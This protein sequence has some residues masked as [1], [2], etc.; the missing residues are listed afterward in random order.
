MNNFFSMKGFPR[1]SPLAFL[2][3]AASLMAADEA[4][5]ADAPKFDQ[6]SLEFYE[7]EVRP[8]L[9]ERC[10]KCHSAAEGVS[11]GGLVM[12][13]RAGLI[14]GGD[15]GPS[16]VP[17]NLKKSLMIVAIHQDD[18]ELSMPPRKAGAKLPDNQ[19]KV[20][21]NWVMMGA[22][23]PTGSAAVKLTGLSQKARDHWA[24]KPVT[25]PEVPT[26]L[27]NPAWVQNEIDAFVLAKLDQAGLKPSP[28][29]D[30][31]ALIRRLTYDLHGLPPTNA[32]AESF[33]RE[34][35]AAAARDQFAQ[36]QG[37]ASHTAAVVM[38]RAVDRLLASPRYGERWARHWLDT[39]RYSDTKG[40]RRGGADADV[41]ASAWT[42]R[43]Y[44]I[45]AFNN[46]KPY[47]QFIIEQLAADRLPDLAKDDP[48]LAALGFIT[49]GKRFDNMDDTIDERIDT[50]SKAFMA[51]TVACARCHDHK[52][53]PIPSADY[54][55]MHGIF[56]STIEPLVEPAIRG[57]RSAPAAVR[58]DYE[59]QMKQLMDE[60]VKGYYKYTASLISI[61][62]REFGPRALVAMSGGMRSEKGFDIEKKFK[63]TQEREVDGS[64]M[65]N[66]N[67]PITG[68]LARLRNL[69]DSEFEAKAPEIIAAALADK[70]LQVNPYIAEG[71]R[72]LK[73]KSLED[74][75]FAYQ[76]IFQ[77][78]HDRILAHYQL[79]G[80][81]G[82]RGEQDDKALAQLAA[83][84]WPTPSYEDIATTPMMT[85]LVSGRTFCEPWQS[86][87]SFRNGN[88][89][90]RYFKF[91]AIN[92][93]EL[94][95]PGGPGTAMIVADSE[96]PHDTNVYIRGDRN[97]KGAVAP[98]QFLEI[99]AGPERQPFYEGS[100]RRE[101]AVS[102]ASRTNPLT[103]R[104]MVNRVWLHHFGA[105]IVSTPDDF[106][107]MS[108]KPSHPELLDW[109]ATYFVDNG[110]SI[111]KLH[112]KILLSATYCQSA[113]PAVN[114]LVAQKGSVDPLKIDAGNKLLWRANLRRLDFE[115]IRDSM[116]LLTGK[117]DTTLGGRPVNITE[118]PFSYRRSIYGFIRRENL[119]DLQSQFDFADPDMTNSRRGSTIVPQQALF[120]MNNALS[121]DVARSV[122]ARPEVARASSDDEKITQLYKIMYQR[123]PT[124]QERALARDF[125]HRIGGYLDEK[126]TVA[127]PKP[128][129]A[130]LAAK[131]KA[132]GAAAIAAANKPLAPSTPMTPNAS[133]TPQTKVVGTEVENLGEKVSRKPV[134]PWELLAQS[135]ICANEFVYLN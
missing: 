118:E 46:D 43:D 51:L 129:K 58:A 45:D 7:K 70:R 87:P 37:Q 35:D 49:V 18:P 42:Y 65:I 89:P 36:R 29:A 48:R 105:G 61:V 24:F 73:P 23:A 57:T 40:V 75:T 101:L 90:P 59:R 96:K 15:Q 53:D 20:L 67:S 2:G 66:N 98:R 85:V 50:T 68:P 84:P 69:K 122:V 130:A 16:V 52:F 38:E 5:K 80:T 74:V 13:T 117:M 99:L 108:E 82:R 63:L 97:K 107:N 6:A 60:N 28:S 22:P 77:K 39:A 11:K 102:I 104:V 12:D 109:L 76:G 123:T 115:S 125:V 116:L 79:R 62:H 21:E 95:H 86:A 94:T 135:M 132:E 26:K 30:G 8:I 93:L 128:D 88:I 106:G 131:R 34:Y 111:K 33:A 54:Y 44:V 112:K 113:N 72:N 27:S 3:L 110:W 127:A 134:S 9:S 41:S 114:P 126:P 124:P 121:V 32:E 64:L 83:Y 47:D 120:F 25:E 19:I 78:Y 71:L 17:G 1:I 92:A 103:S 81:P 4:A 133:N 91:D 119:S 100:G 31:E 56:S 10:Y 14:A 55:S